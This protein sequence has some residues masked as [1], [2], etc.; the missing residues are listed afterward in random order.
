M[1]SSV[2]TVVGVVDV[3]VNSALLNINIIWSSLVCARLWY[4]CDRADCGVTVLC[5]QLLT[6]GYQ[7]GSGQAVTTGSLA[8]PTSLQSSAPASRANTTGR[9][10]SGLMTWL[11]SNT[12]TEPLPYIIIQITRPPPDSHHS[13]QLPHLISNH[14]INLSRARA[15]F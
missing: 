6:T 8:L 12:D 14:S 9:D 4:H 3:S 1:V 2:L 7:Q 11:R 5:C 13:T 10:Y 15:I